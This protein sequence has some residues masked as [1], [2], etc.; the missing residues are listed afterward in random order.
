MLEHASAMIEKKL[1]KKLKVLRIIDGYK[2]LLPF[3]ELVCFYSTWDFL[4]SSLS[5]SDTIN[6]FFYGCFASFVPAFNIFYCNFYSI[7][8]FWRNVVN[9]IGF[10][11]PREEQALP[12]KSLSHFWKSELQRNEGISINVSENLL[13][14]LNYFTCREVMNISWYNLNAAIIYGKQWSL[15]CHAGIL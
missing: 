10:I 11:L 3:K 8:R 9:F 5:L 1:A 12:K 7:W 14:L 4:F 13:P 6:F 2:P 15:F